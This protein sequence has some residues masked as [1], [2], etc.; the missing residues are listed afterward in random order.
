MS[1]RLNWEECFLGL[2]QSL[3]VETL[4]ED[5]RF[6]RLPEPI[7][8]ADILGS[9]QTLNSGDLYWLFWTAG[10]A[11]TLLRYIILWVSSQKV[12]MLHDRMGRRSR[13]QFP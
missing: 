3:W 6:A 8:S 11:E 9:C 2:H 12:C 1:T 7:G 13:L 4:F 10:S 5:I